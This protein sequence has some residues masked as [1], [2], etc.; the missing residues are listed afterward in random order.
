[1]PS[2][3]RRPHPMYDA[4]GGVPAIDEVEFSIAHVRGCFGNCNFCS[5]AYHQGRHVVSRSHESVIEEAQL[6]TTLPGFKG[7]IH[8][9]GGPTANF[10]NP[11]CKKAKM[12][13]MC[14][15]KSCL[16]PEKCPALEV[17]HSDYLA[18][19]RKLRR[20]PGVRKV[21]IRS[22]IRFD[23]LMA[24][25]DPNFHRACEIPYK[26]AAKRRR[27]LLASQ[28]CLHEQAD[29]GLQAL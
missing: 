12:G 23:Y 8:D 28:C 11:S 3:H 5:I 19:L 22:G 24:D 9:V 29:F 13:K 17:D 10:R 27:T 1:M 25:E 26:R 14:A 6:L 20:L 4:L 21:F 16:S 15:D 2:L 7:Y 18:L